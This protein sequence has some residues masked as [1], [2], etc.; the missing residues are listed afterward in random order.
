MAP[1]SLCV[2]R[3]GSKYAK[4]L[5]HF[6]KEMLLESTQFAIEKISGEVTGEI[7]AEVDAGV[8]ELE[9]EEDV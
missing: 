1:V 8:F 7:M 2:Q 9:E 4:Y 3:H 6:P 5:E